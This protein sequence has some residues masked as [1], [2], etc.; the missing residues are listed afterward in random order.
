M[1]FAGCW[2]KRKQGLEEVGWVEEAERIQEVGFHTV[3]GGG[4]RR[5]LRDHR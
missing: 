5:S 4:P 1:E 2:R 3:F